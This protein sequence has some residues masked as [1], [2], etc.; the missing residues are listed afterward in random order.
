MN[1]IRRFLLELVVLLVIGLGYA[2]YHSSYRPYLNN[3][4]HSHRW[5]SDYCKAKGIDAGQCALVVQSPGTTD[6]SYFDICLEHGE[7]KRIK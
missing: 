2:G 7:L 6:V 5:R 4:F 1:K 3:Q